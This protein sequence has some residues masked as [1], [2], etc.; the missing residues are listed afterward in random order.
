MPISAAYRPRHGD[1]LLIRD[2]GETFA[3]P[4]DQ[5]DH[6]AAALRVAARAPALA[7]QLQRDRAPA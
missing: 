4:A 6:V 3:V 5:A 2:D 7:R 1:V